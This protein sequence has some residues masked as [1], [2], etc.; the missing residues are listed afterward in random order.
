M[1]IHRVV[2][3]VAAAAAGA[4]GRAGAELDK[5][6]FLDKKGSQVGRLLVERR[7]DCVLLVEL[8]IAC[9]LSGD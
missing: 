2:V 3:V 1:V 7:C 6:G 5:D 9:C 8:V 4:E